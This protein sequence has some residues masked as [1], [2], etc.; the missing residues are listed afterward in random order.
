MDLFLTVLLAVFVGLKLA[1]LLAW[2]WWWVLSPILIPFAL[3]VAYRIFGG[4]LR[5][6]Q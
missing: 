4:L 2:T 1:G 5:H 6:P 3:A